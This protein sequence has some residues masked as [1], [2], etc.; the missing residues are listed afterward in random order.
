MDLIVKAGFV[1]VFIGIESPSEES[2]E[3]GH[4]IQNEHRDLIVAV[5]IIQNHG[6]EVMGGFLLVK[7]T[8]IIGSISFLKWT[9]TPS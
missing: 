2:L 3:E 8:P 1:C 5:K 4:K 7:I 6:L 9:G